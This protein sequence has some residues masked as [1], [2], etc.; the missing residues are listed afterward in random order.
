MISTLQPSTFTPQPLGHAETSLQLSSRTDNAERED[1]IPGPHRQ[2]H[3]FPAP[4]LTARSLG[5]RS[6]LA[7]SCRT[8]SPLPK[9]DCSSLSAPPPS[10]PL[11][12]KPAPLPPDPDPDVVEAPVQ[13]PNADD[14]QR[15]HFTLSASLT[16]SSLGDLSATIKTSTEPGR[17][18]IMCVLLQV[19]R[20]TGALVAVGRGRLTPQ[21]IGELLECRD[22][23]AYPGSFIAPP[24]GLFLNTVEYDENGKR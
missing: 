17:I 18:W 7:V 20:M 23:R 13:L 16:P 24:S 11:L 5:I 1:V 14:P 12:L 6:R 21:H 19:R 9:S 2:L 4:D 8:P 15:L 10:Q 22:S 3:P